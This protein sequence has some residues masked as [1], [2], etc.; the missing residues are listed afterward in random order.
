MVER[1]GI[2]NRQR[3]KQEID[4]TGWNKI[5]PRKI[6]PSDIDIVFDDKLTNTIVFCDLKFSPD[7]SACLWR[8]VQYG[9]RLLYQR[10]VLTHPYVKRYSVLLTHSVEDCERDIDSVRDVLWFQVMELGLQTGPRIYPAEV[11]HL[12]PEWIMKIFKV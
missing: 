7:G 8:D 11:G 1:G 6:T 2:R 9:Q 10:L 5:L 4:H 3:Y 12:W